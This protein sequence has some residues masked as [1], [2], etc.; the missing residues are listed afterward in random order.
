MASA[1]IARPPSP[2][3]DST[4]RP[5]RRVVFIAKKKQNT[6]TIKKKDEE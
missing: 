2:K 6:I 3:H 5:R 4:Q 1:P